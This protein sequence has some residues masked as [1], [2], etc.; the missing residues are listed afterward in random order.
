MTATVNWCYTNKSGIEPNH[1][2]NKA[3]LESSIDGLLLVWT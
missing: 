1:K 2:V 3:D